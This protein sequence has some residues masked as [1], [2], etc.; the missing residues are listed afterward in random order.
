MNTH[1]GRELGG[2]RQFWATNARIGTSERPPFRL[3]SQHGPRL[4]PVPPEIPPDVWVVL[5][6]TSPST[7]ALTTCGCPN[8]FWLQYLYGYTY[9]CRCERRVYACVH[10]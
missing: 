2:Q 3:P 9:V 6:W 4:W 7:D 1:V 5:A 8:N 10:M